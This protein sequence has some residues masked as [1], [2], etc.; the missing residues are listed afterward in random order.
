MRGFESNHTFQ[1][2]LRT[3]PTREGWIKWKEV[4]T[5]LENVCPSFWATI[6]QRMA[7]FILRNVLICHLMNSHV[8]DFLPI[9]EEFR[10][11]AGNGSMRTQSEWRKG[12]GIRFP[13]ITVGQGNTWQLKRSIQQTLASFSLNYW[14]G[15]IYILFLY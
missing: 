11:K 13:W 3:L 2:F 12:N 9:G 14:V 10:L 5:S 8:K 6:G 7:F 1:L 4:W 15:G